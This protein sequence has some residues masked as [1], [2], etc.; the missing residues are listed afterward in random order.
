MLSAQDCIAQAKGLA[1]RAQTDPEPTEFLNLAEK[2]LDL[3]WIAEW[4]DVQL[5][6]LH[7]LERREG[8]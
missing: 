7:T 3:S 4:Q 1:E 8:T 5:A 2:W 6:A